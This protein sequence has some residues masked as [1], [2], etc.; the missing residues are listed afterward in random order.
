MI[1]PVQTSIPQ[2]GGSDR[3]VTI[4][5]ILEKNYHGYRSTGVYKIF[6]DAFGDET[7]LFIEPLESDAPADDLPDEQNPDYLGK[8]VF[9][10]GNLQHFEG[11]VLSHAEQAYLAVF[12]ESYQ[13]PDI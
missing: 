12:I 2:E 7:H 13:E 5:P 6:K 9:E 1:N 11:Q 10:Y 8:F 4:E 3:Q